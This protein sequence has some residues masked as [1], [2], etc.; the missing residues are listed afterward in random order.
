MHTPDRPQL[1]AL[2]GLLDRLVERV[3]G[4]DPTTPVERKLQNLAEKQAH[5][6]AVG[7]RQGFQAIRARSEEMARSLAA[8]QRRQDKNSAAA[9]AAIDPLEPIESIVL[10]SGPPPRT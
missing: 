1:G 3:F 4:T 10:R 9:R 5:I 6:R 2:T 8:F 7:M